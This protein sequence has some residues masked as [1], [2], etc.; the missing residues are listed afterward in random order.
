MYPRIN[1]P[2]GEMQPKDYEIYAVGL[3]MKVAWP[4]DKVKIMEETQ[5]V[6]TSDFLK[7]GH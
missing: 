3:D 5:R 6:V 2:Q 1:K 7:I 4:Q